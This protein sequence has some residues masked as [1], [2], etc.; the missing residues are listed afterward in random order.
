MT[1]H[2]QQF[3]VYGVTWSIGSCNRSMNMA[4]HV[5]KVPA[6]KQEMFNRFL[7]MAG[8]YLQL[9]TKPILQ[10]ALS[11]MFIHDLCF[12]NL[13]FISPVSYL[14][15]GEANRGAKLSNPVL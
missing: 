3:P 1:E 15:R 12:G 10:L 8:L 4:E 11:Q 7:Y 13:F 6:H 2:D 5:Q 14:R 9:A